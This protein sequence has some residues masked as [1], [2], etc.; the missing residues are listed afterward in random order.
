MFVH[1]W[2]V[3][4]VTNILTVLFNGKLAVCEA[5]VSG[6]L[7]SFFFKLAVPLPYLQLPGNGSIDQLPNAYPLPLFVL[8]LDYLCNYFSNYIVMPHNQ[9][10]KDTRNGL[11]PVIMRC[12][13]SVP[14]L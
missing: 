2:G 1:Q 5:L 3:V 10:Y 8:V 7:V 14:I 6:C 11:L 12:Y 4:G 13:S 9:T